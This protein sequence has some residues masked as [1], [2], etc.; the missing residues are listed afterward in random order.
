VDWHR[1][2]PGVA[3]ASQA[4]PEAVAPADRGR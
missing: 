3:P 4:E 2:G 1:T